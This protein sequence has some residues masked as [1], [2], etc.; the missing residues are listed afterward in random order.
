VRIDQE[1]MGRAELWIG[2]AI[3]ILILAAWLISRFIGS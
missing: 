2:G 3:V 1:W